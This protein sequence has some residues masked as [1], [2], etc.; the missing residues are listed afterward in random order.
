MDLILWRHAQ[1]EA[2][3]L[4]EAHLQSGADGAPVTIHIDPEQDLRH[5]VQQCAA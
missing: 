1:A 5:P 3:T 2:L 4:D